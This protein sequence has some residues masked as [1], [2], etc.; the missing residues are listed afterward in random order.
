MAV[1]SQTP[2][3]M[4]FL[5]RKPVS[6]LDCN[7]TKYFRVKLYLR[8]KLRV[9]EQMMQTVWA[10]E[11][12]IDLKPSKLAVK[13]SLRCAAPVCSTALQE[14]LGRGPAQQS[15]QWLPLGHLSCV[16]PA[17]DKRP[18][19]HQIQFTITKRHQIQFTL[20]IYLPTPSH[21]RFPKGKFMHNSEINLF[22]AGL[23]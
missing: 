21:P 7:L 3:A 5:F 14:L 10:P 9:Q 19:C 6:E 13:S 4:Q 17:E 20:T 22:R 18:E 11:A 2:L 15:C 1:D 23:G 12:R 16:P 8:T